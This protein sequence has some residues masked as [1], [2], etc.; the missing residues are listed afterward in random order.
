MES[1]DPQ[2]R[3]PEENAKVVPVRDPLERLE[4]APVIG[5]GEGPC[6]VNLAAHLAGIPSPAPYGV[7]METPSRSSS[8]R[9]RVESIDYQPGADGTGSVELHLAHALRRSSGHGQGLATREGHMRMGADAALE[10]IRR[11]TEDRIAPTLVGIKAIRAFD[12][13][14]VI[15]S[16]EVE[17]GE[18]TLRVLGAQAAEDANMVRGAVHAVLDALNRVAEPHL[19]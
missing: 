11:A 1:E 7:M 6:R 5:A 16:I 12:I 10:A 3:A 13:W 17:S 18:Q 15:V 19:G 4:D 9:L 2:S 14:L 8:T